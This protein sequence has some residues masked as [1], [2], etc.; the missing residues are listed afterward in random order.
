M[1]SPDQDGTGLEA[2]V[3]IN[4]VVESPSLVP[5]IRLHLAN[6]LVPLWHKT[7]EEMAREGLPPPFWAFAWAGGQALAR[8]VLDDPQ[9]VAGRDV[10]AFAAGSGVEAIAAAIAGANSVLATDTDPFAAAA[11][12]AN[13]AQNAV[14][15]TASTRN[16]IGEAG[17]WDVILAGDI[18]YEQPLARRVLDWLRAEV[19]RG[20]TVLI[21]DPGRAYLPAQG[22]RK[23]QTCH[24]P[25]RKE[26]EDQDVKETSVYCLLIKI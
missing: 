1:P 24:V 20:V 5:E 11:V 15:V 16:V 25:T 14:T 23:V 21:G 12:R 17:A 7:E 26:L 6:K 3:R 2:F 10:L 9:W 13:A 4:T 18:L 19:A 8:C 22:L